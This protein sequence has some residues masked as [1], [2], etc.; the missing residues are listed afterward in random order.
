MDDSDFR[1]WRSDQSIKGDKIAQVS[2]FQI[3]GF[4]LSRLLLSKP[5]CLDS[6]YPES[7]CL[8]VQI[9]FFLVKNLNSDQPVDNYLRI[10]LFK[11]FIKI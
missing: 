10:K 6:N 3:S 7:Y 9:L 2:G 5:G 1:Y 11:N 8:T 4:Q